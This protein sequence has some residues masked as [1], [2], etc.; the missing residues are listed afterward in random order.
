MDE[1]TMLV[2]AFCKAVDV[3]ERSNNIQGR[4]L[5]LLE[6]GVLSF[7]P[8]VSERNELCNEL[9]KRHDKEREDQEKALGAEGVNATYESVIK[10]A[11]SSYIID[12]RLRDGMEIDD[13]ARITPAGDTSKGCW[14]Q[15][16]VFVPRHDVK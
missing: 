6:T 16:W 8:K 1:Q 7:D 3:L 5:K 2:E 14:V 9:I 15:A 12:R 11:R 4:L 10:A 13:D